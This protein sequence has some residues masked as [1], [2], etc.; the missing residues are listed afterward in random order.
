MAAELHTEGLNNALIILGAAG[1]VIPAFARLR[2]TPIIGFL[3][4]GVLVG[5]MG[6]GALAATISLAYAGLPFPKRRKS[7]ASANLASSCCCSVSDLNCRSAG[8]GGCASKCSGW[9]LPNYLAGAILI[10]GALFAVGYNATEAVG[11]GSRTFAVFYRIGAANCGH[12]ILCGQS[13]CFAMLLFEDLAIV[14]I[15]FVLGVLG[16]QAASG[17]GW[18]ALFTVA[19]QGLAVIVVMLVAG[20]FC[21]PRCSGRPRAPKAPSCSSLRRCWSSYCRA[22]RPLRLV[23][24]RL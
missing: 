2:I 14:P 22:W 8:F 10:G 4:V 21:L 6:L 11:L 18:D 9:V 20:D 5:P 15:I 12:N 17:G 16:P 19:W 13:I 7:P 3:L 23:F 24:P 1:I